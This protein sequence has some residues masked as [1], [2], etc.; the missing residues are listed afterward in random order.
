VTI[1]SFISPLEPCGAQIIL[2]AIMEV[3]VPMVLHNGL[4]EKFLVSLRRFTD[5]GDFAKLVIDQ[6][7]GLG[8]DTEYLGNNNALDGRCRF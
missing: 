2:E 8:Y 6:F 7:S 3:E 5:Q 1:V 4:L